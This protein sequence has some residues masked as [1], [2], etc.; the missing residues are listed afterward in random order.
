[1]K[2]I[3]SFSAM[4]L[5]AVSLFAVTPSSLKVYIN[6][7][8]GGYDSDDR[9][10]YVYP[11]TNGDTMTFAESK[12]NLFKGLAL[13]QILWDSWPGITVNM[14]RVQNRTEDDLPLESIGRAAT[15]WGASTSR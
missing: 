11:F 1:M 4:L 9:V 6:P 2:K 15:Q 12:S 10:I 7:G 5:F 14:S 8:H 3:F 13:R